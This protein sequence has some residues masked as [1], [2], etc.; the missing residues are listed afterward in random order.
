MTSNLRWHLCSKDDFPFKRHKVQKAC[1]T[2]RLK[3]MRCDGRQPC[4]R[5]ET[6]H[7][8]CVYDQNKAAPRTLPQAERSPDTTIKKDVSN[9][10]IRFDHRGLRRIS[11]TNA[12]YDSMR[13]TND[14]SRGYLFQTHLPPLM[15]DFFNLTSQPHSIWS[16]FTSLFRQYSRRPTRKTAVDLGSEILKLFDDHNWLYASFI[17]IQPL[18]DAW[19]AA[20]IFQINPTPMNVAAA[21]ATSSPSTQ[22]ILLNAIFALV[23]HAA[24]QSLS[25]THTDIARD[26]EQYSASFYHEAHHRFLQSAFTS[27]QKISDHAADLAR[28]TILLAHYQCAALCENQAYVTLKM[29]SGFISFVKEAASASE[30]ER[31][32]ALSSVL[33]AWNIWIVF[34]LHLSEPMLTTSEDPSS[35]ET[36]M[37]S[38]TS[39]VL[40]SD[41]AESQQWA[42]SVVDAYTRFLTRLNACRGTQ[43]LSH[44]QITY[45]GFLF[46]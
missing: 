9:S 32:R 14:G 19:C 1:Q 13:Q 29:A 40:A 17:D 31:L 26:L 38:P 10:D 39:S 3:K 24:F 35:T 21:A 43:T 4:L 11:F 7:I 15:F 25:A 6:Q 34:Y 28:A 42:A 8:K 27:Q 41:R 33:N 2:C 30:K 37:P 36:M 18:I 23:C 5:C 44:I 20:P 46:T 22:H 16:R 45:S 12:L